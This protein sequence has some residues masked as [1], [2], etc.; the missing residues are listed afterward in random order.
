MDMMP[1]GNVSARYIINIKAG[2]DIAASRISYTTM[3]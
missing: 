1:L 2:M 3:V